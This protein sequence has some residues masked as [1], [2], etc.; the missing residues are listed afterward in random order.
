MSQ[1][2][3]TVNVSSQCAYSAGGNYTCSV[4]NPT[5]SMPEKS[6]SANNS[7]RN[8]GPVFESFKNKGKY[9]K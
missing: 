6:T 1:P 8:G 9:K 7:Y 5:L 3:G 2:A 4:S